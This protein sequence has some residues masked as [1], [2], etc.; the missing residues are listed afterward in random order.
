MTSV[1]F[2]L[3]MTAVTPL[4]AS[5]SS[6]HIENQL[7]ASAD[8][9]LATAVN[10][11]ELKPAMLF[12]DHDSGAF[13]NTSGQIY[14]TRQTAPHEFGERL[15]RAFGD[16]GIGYNVYVTYYSKGG[17]Q[18]IDQVIYHGAPSDNAVR[19]TTTVPL[20]DGESLYDHTGAETNVSLNASSFYAPDFSESSATYNV[21]KVEVVAWRI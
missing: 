7:Q 12:W 9:V 15:E 19:S 8:G 10:Q 20:A 4:S 21:L 14:Y 13:H 3:Q 16:R 2:V 17:G 5:T 11:D 1:G 18:R 6:Q